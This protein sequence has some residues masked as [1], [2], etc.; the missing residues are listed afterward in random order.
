M[1]K[2]YQNPEINVVKITVSQMIATS[3]GYGSSVTSAAGAES[4]DVND[5]WDDDEY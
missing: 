5:L 3:L 1:K 2:I 4:R